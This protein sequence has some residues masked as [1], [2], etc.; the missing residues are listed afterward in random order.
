MAVGQTS[1]TV[2]PPADAMKPVATPTSGLTSGY[3]LPI[4]NPDDFVF[5]LESPDCNT[6]RKLTDILLAQMNEVNFE[7]QD[8]LI[9][10]TGMESAQIALV[11]FCITKENFSTFKVNRPVAVGVNLPVLNQFFKECSGA[12]HSMRMWMEND[13][14]DINIML[15]NTEVDGLSVHFSFKRMEIEG[16]HIQPPSRLCEQQD[17]TILMSSTTFR[18]RMVHFKEVGEAVRVTIPTGNAAVQWG[19]VEAN[20]TIDVGIFSRSESDEAATPDASANVA[21]KIS[22]AQTGFSKTFGL[23]HLEIF[24]KAQ[25]LSGQVK[26]WVNEALPACFHFDL[27]DNPAKGFARFWLAPYVDD[28][29]TQSQ[30]QLV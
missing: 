3:Q 30:T 22:T 24:S 1:E 29:A 15:V 18:D 8:D 6:L 5:Y 27:D 17:A 19:V 9:R 4:G 14:E 25:R 26:I 11:D 13:S 21:L 7:F 28:R 12:G 16:G 23:R 20:H 10:V 2:Q